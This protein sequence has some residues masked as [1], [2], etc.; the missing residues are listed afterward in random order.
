MTRKGIKKYNRQ[1]LLN[2]H[3][4]RFQLNRVLQHRCTFLN[5]SVREIKINAT[6]F[7]ATDKIKAINCIKIKVKK[8]KE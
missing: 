7:Y 8:Q 2:F 3:E 5:C 4:F 6:Q 1:H